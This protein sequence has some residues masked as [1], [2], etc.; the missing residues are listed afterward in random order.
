MQKHHIAGAAVSIVEDDELFLAKGYGH[1]DL[2][3]KILVD[4]EQ[5]IFRIGSVG[6]LFTWTA[7]MQLL[8]SEKHSRH[9]EENG[10]GRGTVSRPFA[11]LCHFS[12]FPGGEGPARGLSE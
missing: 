6:K 8:R 1:A 12:L 7:V 4:P 9:L 3:N 10:K 2:E 11:T 5:S